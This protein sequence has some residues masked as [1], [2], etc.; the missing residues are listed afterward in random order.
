LNALPEITVDGAL[1]V[2]A[3]AETQSTGTVIVTELSFVLGSDVVD[4]IVASS[5]S[6]VPR[7]VDEGVVTVKKCTS[8]PAAS[9]GVEQLIGPVP[10]NAG[11]EH[12]Q[13]AGGDI[14]TKVVLFGVAKLRT[15]FCAS[16]GPSL[17]AL[18]VKATFVP[19]IAG[20]PE[21]TDAS[22]ETLAD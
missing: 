8:V 1:F 4:E 15:T 9:V 22:T 19:A 11:V 2:N 16:S 14:E 5:S 13:P 6:S 12:D 18:S 20:E 21:L 10:P 7:G 3:R 17:F